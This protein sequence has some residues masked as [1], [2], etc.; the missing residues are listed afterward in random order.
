MYVPVSFDFVLHKQERFMKQLFEI[1]AELEAE[2]DGLIQSQ[3]SGHNEDSMSEADFL[4]MLNS[5]VCE[6]SET[7]QVE[8]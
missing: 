1:F 4:T 6:H 3:P 7:R 5:C 8:S 2:Q